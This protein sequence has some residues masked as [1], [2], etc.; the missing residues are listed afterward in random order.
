MFGKVGH[1]DYHS[2]VSFQAFKAGDHEEAI[3]Y[4]S[5]SIKLFPDPAAFNNRAL[6]HIK[7]KQYEQ[8]VS[9]CKE[10]LKREPQ[11]TK[12]VA[13]SYINTLITVIKEAL[14]HTQVYT[15]LIN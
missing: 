8:A 10:T 15:S 1:H 12:G 3:A 9:D 6:V 13:T 2:L 4:Y 5:R 7:M 11:N 14:F